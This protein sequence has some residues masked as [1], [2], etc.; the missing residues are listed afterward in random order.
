MKDLFI[1]KYWD[2]EE[3]LFLLHFHNNEAVRQIEVFK[4]KT[5]YLSLDN[6]IQ[7]DSMLYDQSFNDL[8]VNDSD[9]ISKEEFESEWNH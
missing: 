2:E 9:F 7:G 4:G 1:K 6:P 3:I 8:E 5:V